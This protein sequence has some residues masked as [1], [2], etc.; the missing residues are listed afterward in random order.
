[1]SAKTEF[2]MKPANM[3]RVDPELLP[4]LERVPPV[5]FS[6]RNLELIRDTKLSL[7]VDAEIDE[8]VEMIRYTVPNTPAGP[9]VSVRYWRPKTKSAPLPCILHIHGGGFVSGSA[10]ASDPKCRE[11][12]SK[13][14]CI[15]AS[16]EYR[17]AP[18]DRFPSALEDCFSVLSWLH[19]EAR[20]LQ[21]RPDRIG[22]MGESAGGGLAAA[23]A[24]FTRDNVGPP[25]AFQHLIYPM[26]DDRTCIDKNRPEHVGEHIWTSHNNAFGWSSLLGHEPGIPE[27]SCYA[28]PARADSLADLPPAFILTGELDLFAGE[29]IEF[30]RRLSHDGVA[31]ELH[32]YPGCFHAFD[33]SP[34]AEIAAR[35]RRCSRDALQRALA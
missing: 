35:A 27:T 29:N 7:P 10:E 20:R 34:D 23:L 12:A 17:L 3:H 1:M 14:N 30:A 26:L 33:L 28:A 21:I 22:V 18:E 9:D 13:L 31:T 25:L 8:K 11:L 15:V 4:L 32:V 6:A 19:A 16:V 2:I 24:L 5:A